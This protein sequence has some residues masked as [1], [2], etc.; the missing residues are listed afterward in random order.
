VDPD[1]PSTEFEAIA[2]AN[3]PDADWM[4]VPPWAIR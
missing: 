3:A 1:D 4:T 2:A